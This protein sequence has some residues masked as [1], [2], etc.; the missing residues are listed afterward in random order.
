MFMGAI[1]IVS[2]DK[3]Y[4]NSDEPNIVFLDCTRLNGS[5]ALVSRNEP[6]NLENVNN[7]IKL[8]AEQ[9]LKIGVNEIVLADDVIFS[10]SVIQSVIAKFAYLKIKVVGVRSAIATT[11]SYQ[12][13]N[14]KLPLK[15]KCAYLLGDRVIDQ[16]CERDFYFGVAQSG[17]SILKEG[18][19]YKAPYFIPFGDPVK[20]ASIPDKDKMIFSLDCLKRSIMLWQQIVELSGREWTIST[21][22]EKIQNTNPD[23]LIVKK[24]VKEYQKI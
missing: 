2:L 8:L 15:L 10:G 23:D 19:I 9:F 5:K 17:I 24:L 1:P 3:I 4:L 20:R 12:T 18:N 22:P 14:E 13:L 11:S 16:I 7:Q 6:D 21:L